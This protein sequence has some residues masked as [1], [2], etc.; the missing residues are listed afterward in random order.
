MV[1]SGC[2]THLLPL[3]E[4]KLGEMSHLFP[5]G[6]YIW[7]LT[8][9]GSVN[10]ATCTLIILPTTG[11]AVSA[12]L[13]ITETEHFEQQLRYL[14]F[15]VCRDD[16]QQVIQMHDHGSL[17]IRFQNTNRFP[18]F[19]QTVRNEPFKFTEKRRLYA[20]I[21]QDI[22][23]AEESCFNTQHKHYYIQLRMTT[24]ANWSHIENAVQ[25]YMGVI[26]DNAVVFGSEF[27]DLE[28]EDHDG[29]G[30]IGVDSLDI[31]YTELTDD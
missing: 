21:G 22:L 30:G 7:R 19:E 25:H 23:A 18:N 2:S 4:H 28:D 11:Q 17:V 6:A 8:P 14:R 12:R 26:E 9:G 31:F 16:I 13:A 1:D 20:L 3:E 29:D 10:E 24:N 27:V 5:T 15:H